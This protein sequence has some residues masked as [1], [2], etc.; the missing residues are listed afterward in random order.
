MEYVFREDMVKKQHDALIGFV[1]Q[2]DEKIFD[3]FRW[4]KNSFNRLLYK[5]YTV[6]MMMEVG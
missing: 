1:C 3:G 2:N 6:S 4:L 5:E